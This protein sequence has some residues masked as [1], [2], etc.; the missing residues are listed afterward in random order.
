MARRGNL[1]GGVIGTSTLCVL[2]ACFAWNSVQNNLKHSAIRSLDNAVTKDLNY[3]DASVTGF[4][5]Y[6]QEAHKYVVVTAKGKNEVGEKVEFVAAKYETD[7]ERFNALLKYVNSVD[8]T[9]SIEKCS[10]QLAEKLLD[11]V[12]HAK[13]IGKVERKDV[14]YTNEGEGQITNVSTPKVEGNEAYYYI[15]SLHEG[16]NEKGETGLI[17]QIDKVSFKL[18]KEIEKDPSKIFT[19]GT[20]GAHIEAMGHQ[21]MNFDTKGLDIKVNNNINKQ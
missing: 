4:D 17:T 5:L 8:N 1:D 15:V 16:V 11:V 13:F 6:E 12:E 10:R 9:V 14:T 21:F 3:K 2:L 7:E 19:L 20:E 18:T